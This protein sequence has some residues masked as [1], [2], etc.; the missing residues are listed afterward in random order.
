MFRNTS[1]SGSITNSSFASKVDFVTGK[2]ND[3][4]E[5]ADL[6]GDGKLDLAV[7]SPNSNSVNVFQNT[8]TSGTITSS[9]FAAKV[10]FTIGNASWTIAIG[11]L[12]GDNKP[13]LLT[14]NLGSN[15]ISILRNTVA[16]ANTRPSAPQNLAV[17]DS[18]NQSITIKWRKNSEADFMRYRV[19]RSTS[20]SPTT[21]IDSTAGG[22]L[23]DTSR[24]YTELINGTRYYFRVTAVDSAE[25]ESGFSN[26]VSAIPCEIITDYDGN[27]YQTVK[28]G[29]Q[30]WMKEN[31]KV[32]HYQNGDAIPE[33]TD[34]TAWSNLT[35]GAYCNYNNDPNNAN[36]YG[37]LYN[38][39]TVTDSRN[40]CPVGWH[41]PTDAEWTILTDF[42]GGE[43][44][45]GGKMKEA[46]TTH[47]ISPNTGATNESG[48]TGLPGGNR[49][50]RGEFNGINGGGGWY[51]STEYSTTV[52]WSRYLNYDN[53]SVS[54][55]SFSRHDGFSVRCLKDLPPSV[56]IGLVATAGNGQV[57]LKWNKNTELDFL[58]YRIYGGTS[59][60]PT[61]QI[62]STTG[63]ITDTTKTIGGLT[64]GTKYYF[65][66]TA[67]NSA[68]L[69]S[70]FSNEVSATPTIDI[71]APSAP[72]SAS[73][74]PSSW[75]NN[76]TSIISWTNP[77]D[78]TGIAKVWYRLNAAPDANNPGSPISISSPSF[79]LNWTTSGIYLIYFYLEDGAGNK[80]YNNYASVTAKFDNLPPSI[81]VDSLNV[82]TYTTDSPVSIPVSAS[83]QDNLSGM[84]AMTLQYRKAGSDWSTAGSVQ[85]PAFN[86]STVSIPQSFIQSNYQYG[87]DY[88]VMVRDSADN[89]T[90]SPTYSLTIRLNHDVT[91]TD[92][93]GA[94]ISQIKRIRLACGHS[95]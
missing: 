91:R 56:P 5:T 21:K 20:P 1:T 30:I 26:E 40:L 24:T 69:E 31:L 47:W 84:I 6:D 62:D 37:R 19:Y 79:Q 29:N 81:T 72:I 4:I 13:D 45:A 44:V 15:T 75:S 49:N 65:R 14:S 11:D 35:T 58:R 92:A 36:I 27:T 70:G 90:Y 57:T 61:Y 85:Y 41:M 66:V 18:S 87:I 7:T 25:L 88:R 42:L 78:P 9:S 63:G 95:T 32:T 48:F 10:D 67:V 89:I 52:A 74:S 46:G 73:I 93:A 76:V 8:S 34:N 94:P 68:E 2:V 23:S 12:D 59:S 16:P 71:T 55:N 64:N 80:D 51:S 83:A 53:A 60:N 22:N 54:R 39:Y 33:V 82:P 50:Y 86:G 28:I 43:S 77:S 3:G 38:W 17:T